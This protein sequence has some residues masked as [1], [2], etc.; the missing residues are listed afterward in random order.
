MKN[1]IKRVIVKLN[2][3]NIISLPIYLFRIF[4]IKNNKVLCINF[5]GKPVGD[6]PKYIAEKLIKQGKYDIVWAVKKVKKD[7]KY[8]YVKFN[9]LKYFYELATAKILINNSRFDQFIK[10]RKNQF[11]IQTWHG[12]LA[13]KKIEYDAEEKLSDY[14]KKVMKNDNKMIDL[15]ISNSDF[16]T[17]MYRRGFKYDGDILECGSPR[18]DLLLKYD[19]TLINK[20]KNHFNLK[21]EKILLYAPTFRQNYD[22]NPYDINFDKL[23]DYLERDTGEKWYIITKLHPRIANNSKKYISSK[24]IIDASNYADIQ[25][26][27]IACDLLITDYSSTMFEAMI[28]EKKVIL[29]A[30][31]IE[32]Y[33]E[34]R[35]MYFQLDKLPF[36]L[37]QNND[38]LIKV[39]DKQKN[40]NYQIKYNE[41]SKSIGLKETGKSSETI[42]KIIEKKISGD[43]DE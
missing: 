23:K 11:Y 10:K 15:M 36:P 39:I 35:G 40:Y 24:N 6:N 21:E 3:I 1:K 26:L 17:D 27:I 8:R 34:E 5:S 2:L 29:Y 28:A 18:N 32:N 25:E 41:F 7:E 33:N 9:S 13:L 19:N 20:V 4:R 22:N 14:Y 37:A 38:E 30:N 43:N 12:G 42:C 31:D 16:C